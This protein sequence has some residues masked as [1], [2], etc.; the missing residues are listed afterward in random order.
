MAIDEITT[1]LSTLKK[2]AKIISGILKTSKDIK[3]NKEIIELQNVIRSLHDD[4]ASIK[5]EY[6]DL[7]KIKNDLEKELKKIQKLG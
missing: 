3:P 6:D 1:G 5:S 2:A 7:V 4:I